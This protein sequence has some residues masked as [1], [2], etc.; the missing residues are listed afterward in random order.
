MHGSLDMSE[1]F[2]EKIEMPEYPTKRM[3]TPGGRWLPV[4]VINPHHEVKRPHNYPVRVPLLDQSGI[5]FTARCIQEFIQHNRNCNILMTG[6]PGLGKS[7]LISHVGFKIDPKFDIGNIAFWLK[8]FEEIFNKNP[9][10]DGEAGIYPQVDMDESAHAMYGPEY[11]KEE[12]RVLAKNMIISR[13]KRNII[14]FATPKRK[15]L[16]PHVREMVNVW[17][18]VTEPKMFLPG[19]A[20]VRFA[21]PDRQSEFYA[22]KFWVLRYAFIFPAMTGPFWERYEKKKIEFLNE[23]S[24]SKPTSKEDDILSTVTR[25]LRRLGMSQTEIAHILERNQSTV[26][27]IESKF[28]PDTQSNNNNKGLA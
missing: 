9:Y 7:T 21:P 28:Q 4:S 3:R 5:G 18:H 24:T 20:R 13:I 26:S 17:I 27:R 6:D 14:W 23:A 12:Q 8:D 16:N 19:Y 10:G 25:N 2:T 1:Q 15:L 22:E 11:M